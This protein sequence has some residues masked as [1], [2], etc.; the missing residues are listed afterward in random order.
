MSS[1]RRRILN[2]QEILS[3]LNNILED[4]SDGEL[5]DY[6]DDDY[7]LENGSDSSSDESDETLERGIPQD[8]EE[9][10]GLMEMDARRAWLKARE[11]VDRATDFTTR[12]KSAFDGLL[13]EGNTSG[14]YEV[15]LDLIKEHMEDV[16]DLAISFKSRGRLFLKAGQLVKQLREEGSRLNIENESLKLEVEKLRGEIDGAN[17]LRGASNKNDLVGTGKTTCSVETQTPAFL[18]GA[19]R[20]GGTEEGTKGAQ[21]KPAVL[22][23]ANKESTW[24]QVVGRG[25]RKKNGGKVGQSERTVGASETPS[26]ATALKPPP[27]HRKRGRHKSGAPNTTAVVLTIPPEV[28]AKGLTYGE[29]LSRARKEIALP[30]LGI[31][32]GVSNGSTATG[33]RILK[34]PG[35]DS[36]AQADL[37]ASK[38]R[39]LLGASVEVTRPIKRTDLRV[40]EL[41]DSVTSDELKAALAN[42]GGCPPEQLVMG[43]IGMGSGGLRMA[44]LRCPMAAADILAKKGRVLVGWTSARVKRLDPLP[45]RC[46]KCMGTGHVRRVCPSKEDRSGACFRCGLL[47]LKHF[48]RTKKEERQTVESQTC[49]YLY[50]NHL[51]RY[52]LFYLIP[53]V[54]AK[55][56]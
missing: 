12:L 40:T 13:M 51:L 26:P 10:N 16:A 5:L 42:Q 37:L 53:S 32:G 41:D 50:Y 23:E 44:L 17:A 3:S 9:R 8:I 4:E 47:K 31:S 15:A 52:N 55:V 25:R 24:A 21:S 46:F 20:T 29:V 45:L 54:K 49:S 6:S 18:P 22:P 11:I 56:I 19:P 27:T 30:E 48:T 1:H 14:M 35:A 43:P 34:V 33:A 7:E 38:L 2:P 28:E 36:G 39:N